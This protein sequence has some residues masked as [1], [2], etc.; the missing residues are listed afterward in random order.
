MPTIVMVKIEK[1]NQGQSTLN[2]VATHNKCTVII[3]SFY[4]SCILEDDKNI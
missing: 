1:G 3:S 2:N 4:Q